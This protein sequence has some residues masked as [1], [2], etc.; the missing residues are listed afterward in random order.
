MKITVFEFNPFGE[1]TYVI[2]DETSHE[3]AIVDP[4]MWTPQECAT[5]DSFI[6]SHRLSVK[7]LLFTHMH[8]DH[9]FGADFARDTYS[10]EVYA[11][12]AD[13]LLG[14]QRST[15]AKRFH[16]PVS[17]LPPL[18]IGHP[19]H[20]GDTLMLGSETI[21]VLHV[22]GHSKGSV[23]Y[24]C[25]ESKMVLTGD[26]LFRNGIGRT[27]LPG[28]DYAELIHSITDQLL[29]LPDDTV[30]Y[31]GHGPATTISAEKAYNPY[32]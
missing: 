13:A 20:H 3:A 5:L 27:D 12:E 11:H 6:S 29:S 32:L 15:Q 22:P 30:V 31:P 16:L 17:A 7:Y 18:T 10:T 14:A 28:G 2:W 19:L 9:T 24:Y 1:H 4:G 23:A 25:P 21:R 8:I 26:A